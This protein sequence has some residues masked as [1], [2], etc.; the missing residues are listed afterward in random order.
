[1]T[2]KDSNKLL[3]KC[4]LDLLESCAKEPFALGRYHSLDEILTN[5]NVDV[6]IDPNVRERDIPSYFE[7]A[8]KYW[9]KAKDNEDNL[10][11]SIAEENIKRIE[12]EKDNWH[13][14]RLRGLY[15]PDTNQMILFPNEMRQEKNGPQHMDELLV[16]TL[17]HEAMHAYFNRPGH[18]NFPYVLFVEEPLAE[19]GM[20]LYLHETKSRYY[21]WAYQDVS[22]KKTCYQY[23][24]EIMNQYQCGNS[25]RLIR[26]YLEKYKIP[27]DANLITKILPSGTI[28]LPSKNDTLSRIKEDWKD[29]FSYPPRYFYDKENHI[30]GLDGDWGK[31]F[32]KSKQFGP[33]KISLTVLPC[34]EPLYVY[35][36]DGFVGYKDSGKIFSWLL[37]TRKIIISQNNKIFQSKIVQ[38]NDIIENSDEERIRGIYKN[39][40]NIPCEWKD[41]FS[42]SPRYFYDKT[43]N[44]LGLDGDW[45]GKTIEGL[46]GE[47]CID[48]MLNYFGK[49]LITVYLGEYF[50][51]P[52]HR[53]HLH[54]EVVDLFSRASVVISQSNPS[55]VS[56]NGVPFSNQNQR[57]VLSNILSGPY[58]EICRNGKYGL[59]DA[60]CNIIVETIYDHIKWNTDGTYRVL[61]DGEQ[62]TIDKNGNRIH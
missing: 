43:N 22:S 25:Q 11:S 42:F 27:L 17:A 44:I 34:I 58:F 40:T 60:Q 54:W 49:D 36:G 29:V 62:Y 23:G 2:I 16:S 55:L 48:I 21:D 7:E 14:M 1:M 41:M 46:D 47:L 28:L 13:T 8:E 35:L 45:L 32:Q 31:T 20:L 9:K 39:N 19:F 56:K 24:A 57:P 30:L 33:F 4:E 26:K 6:I 15:D 52:N 53:E 59:V 3:S 61:K 50:V 38:H 37:S 10:V 51:E 5:L 18:E 12:E